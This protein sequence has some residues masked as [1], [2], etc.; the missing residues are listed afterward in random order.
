MRIF[1]I[2]LPH[3]TD[4]RDAMLAQAGRLGLALEIVGA[5]NGNAL[6]PERLRELAHDYPACC[7]T[8]GVIGCALSHLK[9]YK[10]MIDE[11][12]PL[13]LV[14]EDDALP[15]PALAA[16]LA[17]LEEIDKNESPKV[18]L[19]SSHYYKSRPAQKLR[20]G[21]A[22]HKFIDGSQGH[23]YVLNQKAAEALY[24]NLRPVKWEADKWYY[25]EQMGLVSVACVVPHVI[26]V[27]G[28]AEKSDLYAD[29]ILLNKKRRAYLRRLAAV[30]GVRRRLRKLFWKLFRR[31]FARKS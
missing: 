5:V 12:V 31:P 11:A 14:M 6:P 21:R 24:K 8:P 25:F 17:D 28:G 18:W 29:R 2:N 19:L 3:R 1:V 22:I 4:K 10:K 7:L 16:V 26:A 13:A 23:G 30:V 27:D 20:G 9:I 15:G